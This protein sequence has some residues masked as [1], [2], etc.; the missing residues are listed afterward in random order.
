MDSEFII[1]LANLIFSDLI[2][3]CDHMLKF[4]VDTCL[5]GVLLNK[6]AIFLFEVVVSYISLSAIYV[7][8]IK[9]SYK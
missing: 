3:N 4:M 7:K 1:I 5:W 2:S 9:R 8:W 6:V